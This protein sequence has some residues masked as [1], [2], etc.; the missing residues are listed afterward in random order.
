VHSPHG[1]TA[2]LCTALRYAVLCGLAALLTVGCAGDS[3][4]P[5][6]K[7]KPAKTAKRQAKKTLPKSEGNCISPRAVTSFRVLDRNRI[8]VN[9]YPQ[10]VI[11]LYDSCDGVRFMEELT[12]AGTGGIICDYRSDAMIVDGVRCPIAAIRDYEADA[13]AELRKEI[14]GAEPESSEGSKKKSKGS[15]V[16]APPR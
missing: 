12:F 13:D 2:K 16:E 7:G 4:D 11:E 9:S 14:E 8:L 15:D 6:A 1:P 3:G 5:S 10:R